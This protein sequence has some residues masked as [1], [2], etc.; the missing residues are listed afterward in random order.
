[1]KMHPSTWKIGQ[2]V[3]SSFYPD[4]K[5]IVRKLLQIQKSD[6]CS[7]GWLASADGG[8]PCELCKHILGNRIRLVDSTWFTPVVKS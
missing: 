8:E 2:V 6:R 1:M 3:T 5:A 4:E 7:S